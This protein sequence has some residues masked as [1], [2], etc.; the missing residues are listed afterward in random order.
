MC[1]VR[2]SQ[3][4]I[5]LVKNLINGLATNNWHV[6]TVAVYIVVAGEQRRL[7]VLAE[8]IEKEYCQAKKVNK[9]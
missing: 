2:N 7:W 4:K 9:K 8:I 5:Y 6:T 1:F 3:Q